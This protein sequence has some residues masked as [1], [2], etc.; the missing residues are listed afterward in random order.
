M[1]HSKKTKLVA[2]MVALTAVVVACGGGGGG[3][4][5][6]TPTPSPSPRPT[7]APTPS[8]GSGLS[9]SFSSVFFV[10]DQTGWVA[11]ALG[12]KGVILATTDGGKT[13]ARQY[14][15]DASVGHLQFI[16]A[17]IGW[18]VVGEGS[19]AALLVHTT[20]SGKTWV[21]LSPIGQPIPVV[22]TP[23]YFITATLGRGIFE[24][25][26]EGALME[27]RDAGKT[28]TAV[29]TSTKLRSVCFS[30]AEQGWAVGGGDILHTSDGGRTW[31]TSLPK[32][33]GNFSSFAPSASSV[34]CQGKDVAWALFTG[35][36]GAFHQFYALY[37]T[38]DRGAS[39]RATMSE[40]YPE[41]GV[42]ERGP[43]AGPLSIIDRK[44]AYFGNY[45]GPC[46]AGT[47]SFQHTTDA[48]ASWTEPV[49]IACAECGVL[50]FADLDR[51]WAVGRAGHHP[52]HRRRWPDVDAAVS[53]IT[54][55]AG[56]SR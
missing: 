47:L 25:E 6:T 41:L 51:G 26:Y 29:Q 31:M 37:S 21:P 49:R 43:A 7:V 36:V 56:E 12:G 15:D 2:L 4:P 1:L 40:G 10:D 22:F 13:W 53:L 32:P 18:A 17:S 28:W 39:W 3:S 27:T 55:R 34:S 30:D 11:G 54:L 24:P 16:S 52:R 42:P 45:C 44:T 19:G 14:T 5:T 35:F 9:D 48:G 8:S 38:T 46:A 20:D 50:F 23:R 33:S